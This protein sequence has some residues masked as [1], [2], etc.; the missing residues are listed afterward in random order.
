MIVQPRI[1]TLNTDFSNASL[2]D[3]VAKID[4]DSKIN[5]IDTKLI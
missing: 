2:I 4:S 5:K 3:T 1:V